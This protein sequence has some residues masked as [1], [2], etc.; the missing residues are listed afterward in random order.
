[1]EKKS[2]KQNIRAK[3]FFSDGSEINLLG[4]DEETRKK[5]GS[6]WSVPKARMSDNIGSYRFVNYLAS[7]GLISDHREE[8]GKGWRKFSYVDLVYLELII[9][10]RKLGVK[11]DTIRYFYKT[12]SEPYSEERSLYMGIDWLDIFIAIH[13]GTEMEVLVFPDEKEPPIICDPA[14]MSLFGTSATDGQ[15][16]ISLSVM[17]NNVRKRA[18]IKPVEIRRNFGDLGLGDAEI[19]AVFAIRGLEGEEEE[20]RIHKTTKGRTLLDVKKVREDTELK[21]DLEAIMAKHNIEDF[22]DLELAVRQKGV[23]YVKETASRIYD[24]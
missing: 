21:K 2:D 9:A 4:V 17:V 19:D 3:L 15:I 16:R 20:I 18:G 5:L 14:S 12:F 13:C 6:S 11:A 8:D 1:M 22:T 7:S 23:A 10:L 24:K